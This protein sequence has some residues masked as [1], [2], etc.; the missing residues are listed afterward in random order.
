M[1]ALS[2]EVSE[3]Y[4]KHIY[5][6]S[7]DSSPVKTSKLAAA[8]KLSPAA[9]TEM[10]KRLDE[11]KLVDYRPYRGVSLTEKGRQ[12]ALIV[13]RRHRLW[14]VFLHEVLKVPWGKVHQH[15]E[16]LEHATDN[17]LADYLDEYLGSPAFDPHGHPIPGADGSVDEVDRTRLTAVEVGR[18][19]EIV[20][21]ANENQT[22]LEYLKG[23]SLVPGSVVIVRAQAPFN[24]PLSLE[25]DGEAIVV[26]A[27]AA[28]TLLVKALE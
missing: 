3:N 10:V 2:A 8:L 6:L 7:L 4:L 9:V 25:I 13:L 20:Q 22:L 23:L 19:V 16:S 18:R 26:G 12:R 17:E 28:R 5:H 21:C 14:E 11:Q 27:E 1:G 24:G 15:A